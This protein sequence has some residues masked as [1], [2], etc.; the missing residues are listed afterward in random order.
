LNFMKLFKS[1]DGGETW[2]GP[3]AVIAPP[4]RV[5]ACDGNLWV[6]PRGRLWFFWMQAHTLHDGRWGVWAMISENPNEVR[7]TWSVPRR[8]C[9]GV[10]LNKPTVLASG[11]WLFPISLPGAELLNNEKRMLP[12]FLRTHLI[13][14]MTPE[15][16]KGVEER[17]GAWTFISKDEGT[18]LQPRGR[19]KLPDRLGTHNEHMVVE[20]PDH[21]LLMLV[22]TKDGIG[23]STSQDAGVTWSPVQASGIPHPSSRFFFR[24][25]RSGN[26]LLVKNGPMDATGA[27]GQPV[28]MVRDKLTAFL[29]KDDGRTWSDGLLLEPRECTYPDGDQTF[30]GSICIVYDHGRRSEKEILM[31]R[32]TE[33][34][35]LAGKIVS[36]RSRLAGLV[37]KGTGVIPESEDWANWKGKDDPLI[38]TGI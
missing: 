22:R 15:E 18:T 19:V 17:A 36:P 31:A 37:N 29:S 10:M 23:A 8:L 24:R 13:A 2:D 4:G 35:V 9:D 27:D 30:D 38:F 16:I 21:S 26:L 34:D 11:E 14:L 3:V 33:E 28:R 12:A 1:G 5:R 20:Q 32:F 25:L 7:P 6:D